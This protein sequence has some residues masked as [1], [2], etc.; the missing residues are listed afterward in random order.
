MQWDQVWSSDNLLRLM[1]GNLLHG[2]PGGLMVTL[3]VAAISI[4]LSTI[5]GAGVGVMRASQARWLS[6]PAF[7][8]IQCLRNV[9]L[10]ILIFWAYFVPP[11]FK[12]EISKFASVTIALTFFTSA[13]IAEVVRGGILSVPAGHVEAA[14][15]LA[16][17]RVQIWLW[18]VLPQAFFNMIPALTSRYITALKNTSLAFLIGLSDLT[19]IGKEINARLMTAPIE[20]YMTLLLIYF[21][22]NRGLSSAMRRLEDRPRFNRLFL[23]I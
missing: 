22:V 1:V 18:I 9:P 23:R 21:V 17:G 7:V 6:M 2:Q 8:Y 15:A 10:V 14:R 16:L 13:Y 20:V 12:L 4:L 11:Y 3:A 5:L 19:D